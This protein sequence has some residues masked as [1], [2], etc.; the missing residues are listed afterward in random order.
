MMEDTTQ[1]AIAEKPFNSQATQPEEAPPQPTESLL[2]QCSKELSNNK[3]TIS[4]L[5]DRNA[6]LECDINELESTANMV[7]QTLKSY[8]QTSSKI[9]NDLAE[10]KVFYEKQTNVVLAMMG[11]KKDKIDKMISDYDE[12]IQTAEKD[13]KEAE[14]TYNQG[15]IQCK[16]SQESYESHKAKFQAEQSYGKEIGQKFQNLKTLEA[17]IKNPNQMNNANEKYMALQSFWK[18]LKDIEIRTPNQLKETL[19]ETEKNLGDAKVDFR[20]KES[21]LASAKSDWETK[22]EGFEKLTENRKNE[23]LKRAANI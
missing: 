18:I 1:T 7:N 23:I 21:A 8:E 16:K 17:T 20:E 6:K 22:K 9:R 13:M 5:T 19:R 3:E 14:N 12:E 11:E 2:G 15:T 4:R 10:I